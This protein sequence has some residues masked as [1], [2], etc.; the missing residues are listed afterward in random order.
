VALGGQGAPIVPMGEKL[1]F[2]E[3][4]LF[5]N[6][7]GIANVSAGG[8]QFLAFDICPANRILNLLSAHT[9]K[10]FDENG[11]LASLGKVDDR[12]LNRLNDFTYYKQAD[13]KSW[14]MNSVWKKY[15]VVQK[16]HFLQRMLS[17]LMWSILSF[18]LHELYY[19]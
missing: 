11:R 15:T 18:R 10:G 19:C 3:Y 1:L 2:P 6:I 8:E 17:V 12:L 14:V 7:G 4:D 5:L 9:D 13:P 16:L